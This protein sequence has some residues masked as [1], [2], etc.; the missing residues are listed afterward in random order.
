MSYIVEAN[1]LCKK[2]GKAVV[3]NN[4]DIHVPKGAIYGLIGKNGAGKTTF[5]RLVA[6]LIKPNGGDCKVMGVSLNSKE[7]NDVRKKMST[8]IEIPA[9]YP[10]ISVKENVIEQCRLRGLKDY[11]VADDYLK[12]VSL[13]KDSEKKANKLSLGMKQRLGLAMAMVGDP[14]LIL[15]DEPMN[16]LDPQGIIDIRNIIIDLHKN[17]GI[18]FIISSHLLD[19]LSKVATHYGFISD[20]KMIKEISMEEI[21]TEGNTTTTVVTPD[22]SK[23]LVLLDSMNLHYEVKDDS[24]VV[25]FAELGIED[26]VPKA[27]A[28]GVSVNSLSVNSES[29]ESVY[30][31]IMGNKENK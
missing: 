13:D 18:T 6:G 14:E 24:T 1:S 4:F 2:Y 12:L 8:I 30:L 11:S 21:K 5:M 28:E 17:K 15:L 3:L 22:A 26:F 25:V 19:E 27:N 29:L 16:G 23:L 20:G 10:D 7:S 31:N 9:F